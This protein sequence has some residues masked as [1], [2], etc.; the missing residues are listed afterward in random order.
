MIKSILL[1]QWLLCALFTG[2]RHQTLGPATPLT[3][4]Q[5][6]SLTNDVD[7][8]PQ[9]TNQIATGQHGILA[10]Y[11][12]NDLYYRIS[13]GLSVMEMAL[14]IS[15]LACV[16]LVIT[17]FRKSKQL[18]HRLLSCQNQ[19]TTLRMRPH[20][21]FNALSSIQLHLMDGNKHEASCFLE[22]WADIIRTTI[23]YSE[24]TTVRFEDELDYMTNYLHLEQQISGLFHFTVSYSKAPPGQDLSIPPLIAQPLVENAIKHAFINNQ[25]TASIQLTY[26]LAPEEGFAYI[27]VEDNGCGISNT[28]LKP[29]K[30]VGLRTLRE[31]LH[32]I[33]LTSPRGIAQIDYIQSDEKGTR[34]RVTVPLMTKKNDK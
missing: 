2:I 23:E 26:T 15:L 18:K 9:Q 34:I 32:L 13:I 12:Q 19:A 8:L 17:F 28:G 10:F 3:F 25:S 30:S 20:F 22:Q 14:L 29:R 11:R 6:N 7:S 16:L 4:C 27:L 1:F 31:R 21:I 24:R 33:N 5:S